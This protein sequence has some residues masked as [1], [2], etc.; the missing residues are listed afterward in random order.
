MNVTAPT[1][2]GMFKRAE[3]GKELARR[4]SCRTTLRSAAAEF[5]LRLPDALDDWHGIPGL[6]LYRAQAAHLAAHPDALTAPIRAEEFTALEL[7]CVGLIEDARAEERA[8]H[9]FPQL[10]PFRARFHVATGPGMAEQFDRIARALI[11]P[12]SAPE[13]ERLAPA[14]SGADRWRAGGYRHARSLLPA[15]RRPP[16]GRY[17]KA[18]RHDPLLPDARSRGRCLCPTHLRRTQRAGV[19]ARR[20]PAAALRAPHRL[21][22]PAGRRGR[23][24]KAPFITRNL[25]ATLRG[26]SDRP[27]ARRRPISRLVRNSGG[28]DPK[29]W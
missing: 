19:G 21:K 6:D 18:A 9:R 8:I 22:R 10:R 20:A 29:F 25:S 11:D 5:M 14:A 3:F 27:C 1:V 28:P 17:G 26:V 13:D 7:A 12:E 16:R 23:G 2:E 4:S 24:R 15:P